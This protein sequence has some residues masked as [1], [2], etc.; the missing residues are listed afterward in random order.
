[1]T[2]HLGDVNT[3]ARTA[4]ITGDPDR[5]P[6]L[7]E[8]V[9]HA[10]AGW[11]RRGY[12]SAEADACGV[13]LLIAGTGI[14]GPS[15]AIAVEE[16]AQLGIEQVIRVGTCGSMQ[17]TVHAGDLV[18]SSGSIRDDGT[19]YHYLPPSFPAVPNHWLLSSLVAAAEAGGLIHHVGLTH[20]KDAYYVEHPEGLPLESHWQNQW[21]ILRSA[22]VLA[23]E[24]EAAALFAVA[25]VRRLRAAA[26]LV[27]VDRSLTAKEVL[28]GLQQATRLAARA[29][30][31]ARLP[32]ATADGEPACAS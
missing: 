32:A 22:G 13:P 23:T 17:P 19:S 31:S 14:G 20:C 2:Q 9:G 26:V 6:R 8:A 10:T 21:R 4:I 1:M 30:L 16:L 29:A 24:M 11:S 3:E 27:P 5:V 7:V 18:I 12:V 28:T 15:T 25:T